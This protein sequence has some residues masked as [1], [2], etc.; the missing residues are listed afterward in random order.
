MV[1]KCQIV[2]VEKMK[3]L[4]AILKY[5]NKMYAFPDIKT[6]KTRNSLIMDVEQFSKDHLHHAETVDKSVL[7]DK[8]SKLSKCV[9]LTMETAWKQGTLGNVQ[10]VYYICS[11]HVICV[12]VLGVIHI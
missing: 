6:E 8:P 4:P 5:Q 7:P 10:H 12:V 2:A 3:Y 9:G 1:S 11:T